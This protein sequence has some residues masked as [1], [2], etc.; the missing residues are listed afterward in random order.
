MRR[1]L[2]SLGL[3]LVTACADESGVGGA[4]GTGAAGGDP[5][6]S[7]GG[8]ATATPTGGTSSGGVSSGGTAAGSSPGGTSGGT[9]GADASGGA[10]A[11]GGAGVTGGAGMTGGASM[12]GGSG[13]ATAGNGGSDGGEDWFPCDGDASVYDVVVTGTGNSWT[14]EGGSQPAESANSWQ[15]AMSAGFDRLT[16]GRNTKEA[17]LVMG[18]GSIAANTRLS[19]PSYVILNLCGTVDVSDSGS[20]DQSPFYVR[21]QTDVDIPHARIT[22]SPPYGMFFRETSNVRLGSIEIALRPDNGPG[23]GIRIDNSSN[24][25]AGGPMVENFRIDHL[26]VSGTL[27]HGLETYGLDGLVVGRVDGTDTGESGVLLNRTINAEVGIVH[28]ENCASIDDGYA[29][30]RI[31]NDAGKIGNEWPA[32]NIHVEDVYA[33]DGGRGIFSV[34]GSGGLTIDRIDIANTGNNAILLQNCYNTVIAAESG[35]IAGGQVVLSNDTENTN[36]GRYEPSQNVTLQNLTLDG[37]SVSEA[38]CDL[39]DRGNRAVNI[40]GG[41]VDMCFDG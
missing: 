20:G 32:G 3:L 30:F 31:A 19:V 1:G 2:L 38:W 12:T 14:I 23:I 6:T 15:Q 28:C 35:T 33:R 36:S 5:V 25:G 39:G 37:A 24:A 7:G 22:G 16:P 4:T 13:G 10:G 11:T 17:M 40:S 41:N 8:G 9:G 34:S 29:A 27:S 18:D 21:G 26:T